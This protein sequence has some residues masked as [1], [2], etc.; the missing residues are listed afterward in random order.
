MSDDIHLSTAKIHDVASSG[1]AVGYSQIRTKDL[2][3]G[4]NLGDLY[5]LRLIMNK[6]STAEIFKVQLNDKN[7]TL[8][9]AKR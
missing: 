1:D 7:V 6:E 2:D 4:T 5:L 3:I 8:R 9:A